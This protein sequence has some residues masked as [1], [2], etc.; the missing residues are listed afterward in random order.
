MSGRGR[1]LGLVALEAL[2]LALGVF[3]G[4]LGDQWREDHDAQRL[5]E[6][7]LQR[8]ASEITVN[9]TRVEHV[10]AYHDTLA[11]IVDGWATM[12]DAQPT[13]FNGIGVARLEHGAWDLALATESLGDIE[14]ELA[15]LLSRTYTA[16][17]TYTNNADAVLQAVYAGVGDGL[18]SIY[19]VLDSWLGD[20]EAQESLLLA[21]Y[22]SALK[23]IDEQ[24]EG[25]QPS[26]P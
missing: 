14:A 9:Q 21:Y 22:A 18:A 24:L 4:L 2:L 12:P 5:A 25:P 1:S 3:L 26:S 10:L 17:T 15:F 13:G 11:T 20:A 16:Q 7:S 8:F 23:R 6:E 19:P